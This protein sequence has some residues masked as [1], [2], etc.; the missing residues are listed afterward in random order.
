MKLIAYPI[1]LFASL[2]LLSSFNISKEANT[3]LT[4]AAS[5][6]TA[7]SGKQVCIDVTVKDFQKILS[8]QYSMKWSPKQLKFKEVRGINLAGLSESN[9]GNHITDKGLL[10]FAWYD[11]NIRGISIPDGTTIYQVCFDVVGAAGA[12]AYFQFT[13]HPTIIEISNAQGNF[14]DLNGSTGLIKIR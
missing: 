4:L 7:Q 11:P 10:T 2:L 9:F 6:K 1:A 14:L 12:K 3:V 8:M 13:N 5:N